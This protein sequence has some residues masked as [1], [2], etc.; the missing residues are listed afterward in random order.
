MTTTANT[1]RLALVLEYALG[2]ATHANNL[3]HA[4]SS[5]DAGNVSPEY[6]DLPFDA[7]FGNWSKLPPF[8]SNWTLRASLAAWLALRRDA[9]RGK[10]RFAAALFHTQITAQFAHGFMRTTPSV[11]SLDATPVQMDA[12]GSWYN[13]AA[14]S[15]AVES[16][17]RKLTTRTFQ[18]ARRLVAWSQWAKDSLIADYGVAPEKV[19]VI[20]PG[21]DLSRWDFA[22]SRRVKGVGEPRNL[23]FVGADFERKGGDTL[24]AAW[25]NLPD[26]VRSHARLHLVTKQKPIL[27]TRDGNIRIYSDII[28]ND[29]RLLTLF[30]EADL[31][32]FPTCADCLPLAVM[33]ALAAGLPVITTGVAA[34][35]EAVTDGENG[36]VVPVGDVDALSQAIESVLTDDSRRS[37]MSVAARAVAYERFDARKN[38]RRLVQ[39]VEGIAT[40]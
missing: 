19:E 28:P 31:F 4:V 1:P 12:L 18:A 10:G 32:V 30:A 13:H 17:K 14:G 25:R 38:Y 24:L 16:F 23:L 36:V 15:P 6:F 40:S 7:N 11:V 35:P 34:L 26:A 3:K 20:P 9:A 27:T 29:S 22:G 21:I 5:G 33:E 8:R 39:T 2:H 37:A